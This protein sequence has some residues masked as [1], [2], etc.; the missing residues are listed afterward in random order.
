MKISNGTKIL[1]I[2][3]GAREH[4]IAVKLKQNPEVKLYTFASAKNPGL[5]E[6]SEDIKIGHL[7]EVRE[8]I[9]YAQNI[10]PAF[11]WVGPEI[12]L[13]RGLVDALAKI[14]IPSIGP[15]QKLARLETSKSFTRQ[16]LVEN[17]IPAY[18]KFKV[19]ISEKGLKGFIQELDQFVIKPDGL[20]GGKGVKV[21]G[22]HFQNS[23]EGL[24]YARE[25]FKKD[26]KVIIEEKLIG[27]EFSLMSFSDGKHLVHMPLVQD[28]KRAYIGDKG[29]NTGGMGSYSSANHSLPFLKKSDIKT[30]QKINEKI[31]KILPGYKGIL[32]GNF[33]A[34]KDGIKLI[35][36]N[37]RFGDPEAMN[38]LSILETDLVKISQGIINGNL[39]Q[40]KVK[41][42]K[43]A[44]VCKYV[45]PKGYPGNSIKDELINVSKVNQDKVQLFYASVDKKDDG[46]Y[47]KGS[48]AI[49]LVAKA[50]TLEKAEKIVQE[51]IVK[52]K[53][54][55]F[56]RED[57]GT[58]ALINKRINI[59]KKLRND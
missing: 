11:V 35:E 49:G 48:R 6:L 54:P 29:P 26:G 15:T 13:S 16:L 45:V 24:A 53:G 20:T 5:L 57:I 1:L 46:L 4:A 43:Q 12:P 56:F 30:A 2:G 8:I 21:Q 50:D 33:I 32:Y 19:F 28:H 40:I 39:N 27:Q 41:F 58:Q 51:E 3:N 9:A 47:L 34:I 7:E 42:A 22:D 23:S 14:N 44:T 17:N 52:I 10:K 36:Y 18:P 25:L 31:I 55:V 37:A 59:I 38:V